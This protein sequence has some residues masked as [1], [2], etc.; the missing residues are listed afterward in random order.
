MQVLWS[1]QSNR[2]YTR[3]GISNASLSGYMPG[4]DLPGGDYNVTDVS[5]H[6]PRTCQVLFCE[7][8]H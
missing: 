4:I 3:M 2:E 7:N 8:R 6:D 5:Y 1:S